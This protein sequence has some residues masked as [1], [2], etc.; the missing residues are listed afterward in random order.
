MTCTIRVADSSLLTLSCCFFA[1]RRFEQLGREFSSTAMLRHG[2]SG[3]GAYIKQRDV[4]YVIG[5]TRVSHFAK[6]I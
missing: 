1:L 4:L 2:D 3:G 5:L 6:W